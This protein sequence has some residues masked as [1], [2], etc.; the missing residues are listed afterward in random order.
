[1]ASE[2]PTVRWGIVATGLISSW[3]VQDL[4]LER[5]NAQEN[6]IIQ[7]V[8]FSSTTKGNAFVKEH[9]PGKSPTVYG[10]Y[11]E[12]YADPGV[13]VIYIGTPHAFH[14]QNCLDAIRHGKHILCEKAFTFNAAETR[15]VLDAARN[16]GVYV[17]EAMWTRHFPLVRKLQEVVHEEKAIGKIHRAF[18]DFAMD[19][20]IAEKGSDSRLKNPALGAGSLLD[21]GIYSL[22]WAIVGLEPPLGM[23]AKPLTEAPEK[24]KVLAAQTLS[25]GIDIGTSLILQYIDGRQGLATSN[26]RVKTSNQFCRIEGSEGTVIVEGFGASVPS[27]FTVRKLS[28]KRTSMSLRGRVRDSTGRRTLWR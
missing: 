24:P 18:C 21:I 1:M 16:K 23:G 28:G 27:F 17:M 13:G 6:H 19:Q 5:P 8:G 26:T 15:E 22:T 11:Q 3:F 25:D 2:K 14:R 4:V 12:L 7:A 10:S 20:K 9:V